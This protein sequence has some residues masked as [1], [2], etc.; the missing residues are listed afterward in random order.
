MS[1]CGFGRSRLAMTLLICSLVGWS[2]MTM[3]F[4]RVRVHV[5]GRVADAAVVVVLVAGAAAGIVAA[6]IVESAEPAKATEPAETTAATAATVA[7]PEFP[8][9]RTGARPERRREFFKCLFVFI[10]LFWC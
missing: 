2:E 1:T 3:M 10:K 7:A 9:R 4:L 6:G 5:N 8:S